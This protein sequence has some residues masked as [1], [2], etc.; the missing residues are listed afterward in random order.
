MRRK[1][2]A[3]ALAAGSFALGLPGGGSAAR[4]QTAAEGVE[5][6]FELNDAQVKGR[7]LPGVLVRVSRLGG[8]GEVASGETGA[9]GGW[10]TRLAPGT[11]AI[12][13]R[14]AGY[15]PY[16]S[17]ATELRGDGQ[18]VTVSLS[19]MLEATEAAGRDV[20]I[21]LNWGSRP[22]QV[23]DADSH[24]ACA[25]G[26]ADRHAF[27]RNRRHAG[28]GHSVELDV[29]DTD[30]GGPETITLTSPPNG[31]HLYW[32]HDYSGPPAVLG[33]SDLVV[34][35]LIGSEQV[36]EFRVYRGLTRRAWR[37]F[38]A[39]EVAGEGRPTLVRFSEDEIAE[40]QDLAVPADLQPPE[41]PAASGTP[42]LACPLAALGLIVLMILLGRRRRRRAGS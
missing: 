20:R 4:A 2:L 42:S 6:R 38:K 33:T 37:P 30:W 19:R 8:G 39:I 41:P 13:Y 11:Y 16:T 24:L 22:D 32:V 34:R 25:C 7:Q 18:L 26:A 9:D 28:P 10:A 40:G 31:S 17:E 23:R 27:Y 3:L 35:V 12:S 15:V 5:V 14:L 36:G 1:A 29:D 21:I